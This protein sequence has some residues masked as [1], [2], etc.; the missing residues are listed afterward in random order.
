MGFLVRRRENGATVV[1][2]IYMRIA[3]WAG[4]A[5][6]NSS[7]KRISWM[8]HIHT[9]LFTDFL[10]WRIIRE[11][12]EFINISIKNKGQREENRKNIVQN[13]LFSWVFCTFCV[14]SSKRLRNRY[15]W[16]V[17]FWKLTKF[18][19]R[20][21]RGVREIPF[22]KVKMK[23]EHSKWSDLMSYECGLKVLNS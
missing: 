16:M 2:V 5:D 14:I 13:K 7:A 21:Y 4:N 22:P 19:I 6:K 3:S 10:F 15:K 18:P 11:E 8:K 17:I 9:I 20:S 1:Y 12:K 23:Y